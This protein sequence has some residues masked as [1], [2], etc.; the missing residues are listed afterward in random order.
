MQWDISAE[1]VSAIII[2]II[3]VYA[4]KSSL[5]PTLKNRI[6][7]YCLY[8]TFFSCASNITSTLLLQYIHVVPVW[9]NY[10]LLWF[11]FLCTPLMGVFY[12]LYV[13]SVI[14]LKPGEF[15]VYAT[16]GLLP[17]IGYILLLCTNPMTNL[18]FTLT[19]TAYE[20]GPWILVTY[21]I[22]YLY[23]IYCLIIVFYR[24]GDMDPVVRRILSIFPFLSACIIL[25]Q[26]YL[27]SELILTG[28]A[29]MSSLLIIYLYLQNRQIFT[30]T[31]T[32]QLNRQ[33][34][35]KMIEMYVNDHRPFTIL[36]LSLKE[37]KF[38]NDKF[39]QQIGDSLLLAVC[40]FLRTLGPQDRLFRYGGDEFAMILPDHKNLDAGIQR[41]RERMEL[42]WRITGID[43]TLQYVMAS[44]SYPEVAYTRDECSKGLEYAL[45]KS[46][47]GDQTYY[48]CTREFMNQIQRK[49]EIVEIMKT[50]LR[51]N[52]FELF[53]QPIYDVEMKGFYK[54]EAL[55][56]LPS[57]SLGFVSPDEFIPIAEE[58]GLINDITYQVLDKACAFIARLLEQNI[59]IEAVSVNFSIVQFMQ[60]H[61]EERVLHIIEQ[62]HIPSYVLC[63]EITESTLST[64]LDAVASFI[65]SM[66]KKGIRFLL[67]DFGTGY[68]NIS[69]VLS[70]PLHTIKIDKSLLWK[71]M[72]DEH[73]KIMLGYVIKAFKELGLRVLCEG[74]ENTEQIALLETMGCDLYQGFYFYKPLPECEAYEVFV[75]ESQRSDKM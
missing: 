74:V 32:Q 5:V 12:F 55:L 66:S 28:S 34:F 38:I 40:E 49:L 62:H 57:N 11:Y 30:D 4:R 52:T 19:N 36:V 43:Y 17:A 35:N 33:E 24:R 54:A 41:I 53:F 45:I 15:K 71:A 6:F 20:R 70:I 61:L 16:V 65:K 50:A 27:F 44:I 18:L 7:Q 22:F 23:V 63:I 29:A 47:Q 14:E 51:D 64:N 1:C 21:I 56:R 13:L 9:L 2:L 60:D 72:S 48:V 75:R 10:A 3:M 68:S 8:V 37:F 67:D 69:Y 42:P 31:L 58:S 39:G 73:S 59:R 25:I 26:Q 46:K